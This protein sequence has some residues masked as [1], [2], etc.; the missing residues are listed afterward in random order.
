MSR[1][2]RILGIVALA[3]LAAFLYILG[4]YVR[5]PDLII[6]LVIGVAMAGYDFWLELFR[7]ER[8]GGDGG[9]S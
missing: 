6:M 3:S 7:G 2:D 9:G 5:E 4:S 1:L 8:Q